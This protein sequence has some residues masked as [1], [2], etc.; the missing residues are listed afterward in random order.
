MSV[1]ISRIFFALIST[2]SLLV[3]AEPLRLSSSFWQDAAFQKSFNGSYRIEARIEPTVSTAE[4]GILIEVQ[5]LMASGERKDALAKIEG[6]S[7]ATHSAALQFNLG[8]LYFEE[9]DLEKSVEAY[10]KALKIYPSFRRAHRNLAMVLVRQNEEKKALP[11]LVEAI[12][13]GD[14]SGA[15]FGLLGYCR[16]QEG[17]WASAL[18]AYR[19]AQLSEP[20][21]PEWKA[22][23]AQCLQ[24]L[25]SPEEAVAL[26]NEV[27]A[28]R[29]Q[30]P[31]YASLQAALLLE[32]G[33]PDEAVKAL[34]LPRRMETLHGD[35]LLQLADL[36]LRADR[37]S[38]A[39]KLVDEAFANEK[40]PEAAQVLG[41]TEVAMSYTEWD[42]A[43]QLLAKL[44]EL[45]KNKETRPFRWVSA[46]LKIE[47]EES[48]EDGVGELEKLLKEDPTDGKILLTLG[49]I[50]V[51][52]G[53]LEQGELL[54]ERAT[55]V[56][57]SATEA[58][59]ELARL[60]VD[61]RRYEAALVAVDE[62][63]K[64]RPGGSLEAYREAL[65]NLVD[66]AR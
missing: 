43:K 46:R 36:H 6:S 65:Q 58:W 21:M 12:A 27:I 44:G 56:E 2:A 64:R 18:Q 41:V 40:K 1:S 28:E 66:A 62:A 63:L 29:P 23:V 32:L 30:E 33:R 57:E 19:M 61:A 54:L 52:N 4:R 5:D 51:K 34:E 38:D 15:T 48:V 11:H 50:R 45:D 7:L 14:A 42:L 55:A 9:G 8:N 3:A 10:E 35:G 16:L 17:E 22:G 13:G 53:E 37:L 26:L 39:E 59:V 20:E 24:Q 49:K 25:N 47:S 31:S 60:R